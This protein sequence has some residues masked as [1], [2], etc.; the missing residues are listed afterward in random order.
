MMPEHDADLRQP[1]DMVL[2]SAK[3]SHSLELQH[4]L[5]HASDRD[6]KYGQH[7]VD[8]EKKL[9]MEHTG[10]QY[11]IFFA[12]MKQV[13]ASPSAV[14]MHASSEKVLQRGLLS[15]VPA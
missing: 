12:E 10:T 4:L 3:V 6:A 5:W 1:N 11:D 2:Y 14:F 8:V 13:N 7:R 9:W 15:A